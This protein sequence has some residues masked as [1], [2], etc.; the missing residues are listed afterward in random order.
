MEKKYIVGGLAVVGALALLAWYFTPKK[1][2]DKFLNATGGCGC[3][4]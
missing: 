3:G 2:S 4:A 1:S